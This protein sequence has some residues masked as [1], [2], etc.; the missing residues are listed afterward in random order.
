MATSLALVGGAHIHTPG[1]IDRVNKRSDITVKYVWDHDPARAQKRAE[2]L[3]SQSI[4]DL[5]F[6]EKPLGLGAVDAYRMADAI[7]KAGV[8]FQTGYFMRGNPVIRFLKAQIEAGIFA[9]VT[10]YRHTKCHSGSLGGWFDTEWRWMA[11]R[12]Q[13]AIIH[14]KRKNPWSRWQIPLHR[15]AS[16]MASCLRII[17]GCTHRKRTSSP[18][19][20]PCG[21][22]S[23]CGDGSALFIG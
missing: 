5:N 7:K 17:P 16:G 2:A 11:D 19:N 10:R 6:V 18:C 1:F 12:S 3:K 9:Q 20:T 13:W 23:Q 15:L 14:P 21:C 4:T 8:F 22:L